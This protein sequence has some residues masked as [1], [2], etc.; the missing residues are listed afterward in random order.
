MPPPLPLVF[1]Y[2]A[3]CFLLFAER[4]TRAVVKRDPVGEERAPPPPPPRE[5][6]RERFSEDKREERRREGPRGILERVLFQRSLRREGE[7]ERE[8]IGFSAGFH[9]DREANR[10]VHAISEERED[11]ERASPP[12]WRKRAIPLFRFPLP[13]PCRR[14]GL[15][16]LFPSRARDRALRP[17]NEP[18]SRNKRKC[19]E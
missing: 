11:V 6:R 13:F 10:T 12:Q 2:F 8:S 15:H 18:V 14:A 1:S 19:R 9:G 4:E 16:K 3:S 5:R 17:H 7:R